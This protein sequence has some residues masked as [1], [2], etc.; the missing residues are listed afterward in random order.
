MTSEYLYREHCADAYRTGLSDGRLLAS[1]E[2]DSIAADA[3]HPDDSD[4]RIAALLEMRRAA[5]RLGG[6]DPL[7]PGD[8]DV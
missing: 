8:S 6:L 7:T 4:D 1:R 2:L 5:R 3:I